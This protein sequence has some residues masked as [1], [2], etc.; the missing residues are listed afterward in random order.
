VR[1]CGCLVFNPRC[2]KAELA[3]ELLQFVAVATIADM[4]PLIG[5]NRAFVFEGTKILN[6][7]KNPGS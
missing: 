4:M 3:E 7:T 1:R 2:N 6:K 5:L